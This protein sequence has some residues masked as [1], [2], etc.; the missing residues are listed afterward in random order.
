M[1]WIVL[2][3]TNFLLKNMTY[4]FIVVG[5]TPLQMGEEVDVYNLLIIDQNTF[6]VKKIIIIYSMIICTNFILFTMN[7]NIIKTQFFI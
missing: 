3:L 2:S 5:G 4:C 1:L 7:A 6:E